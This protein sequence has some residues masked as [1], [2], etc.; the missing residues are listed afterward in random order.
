M[1]QH[2]HL[3]GRAR[4][5]LCQCYQPIL[6]ICFFR[7]LTV[8]SATLAVIDFVV[9]KL[10]CNVGDVGKHKL[11]EWTLF[12]NNHCRIYQQVHCL[13]FW[14]GDCWPKRFGC[15]HGIFAV[16]PN[17]GCKWHGAE[18]YSQ[19]HLD[20]KVALVGTG[21]WTCE[22]GR[23]SICHLTMLNFVCFAHQGPRKRAMPQLLL[24]TLGGL[25][26]QATTS[27]FLCWDERWQ[28]WNK[29]RSAIP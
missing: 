7:D 28:R 17:W 23:S 19:I 15:V 10:L 3:R 25:L 16:F 6:I 2:Y 21:T 18:T 8:R 22:G 4:V 26:A 24:T 12:G 14:L 20:C 13:L 9:G 5:G 27:I 11:V 1:A 29:K